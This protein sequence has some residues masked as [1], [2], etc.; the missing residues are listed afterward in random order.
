MATQGKVALRYARA[1]FDVV[2][3]D[4]ADRLMVELQ[5]F[6]DLLASHAELQEVLIKAPFSTEQRAAILRDVVGKMKI[7]KIALHTLLTLNENRRLDILTALL[8]RLQTLAMES[9]N[10]A[11]IW[12][13]GAEPLNEDEK[14]KLESKFKKV[15]GK[16]VH[17]EYEIDPSLIAGLHITAGGRTYDGSV[18]GWLNSVEAQ[19]VGGS[20]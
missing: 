18:A 19:L 1:I 2:R 17:A 20:I 13:R 7:S 4:G 15:L 6:S 16:E 9:E 11:P 10:I 12:V 14:A 3:S 5:Q 8:A